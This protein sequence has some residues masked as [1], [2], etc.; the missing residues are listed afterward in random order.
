MYRRQLRGERKI[1]RDI[2]GPRRRLGS[3][4]KII[5]V[6]GC[7]HAP[8]VYMRARVGTS[9]DPPPPPFLIEEANG[10]I[11]RGLACFKILCCNFLN[12]LAR[13][14]RCNSIKLISRGNKTSTIGGPIPPRWWPGI[15][16]PRAVWSIAEIEY[17]G[18]LGGERERLKR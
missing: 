7:V 13:P 18:L 9:R 6:T 4:R 8:A 10:T 17:Y 15:N 3:R 2:I 11:F 1:A 14:M 5:L 12:Q 16:T